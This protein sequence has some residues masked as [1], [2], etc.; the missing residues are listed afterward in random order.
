MKAMLD[1]LDLLAVLFGYIV[2]F[3]DLGFAFVRSV[4]AERRDDGL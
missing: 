4:E 1:L 3:V 2:S